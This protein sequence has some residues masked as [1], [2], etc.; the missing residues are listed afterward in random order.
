MEPQLILIN[1]WIHDFAAYDLWSKPLGLLYLAGCLRER[2][3]HI[4]LTDCLDVHHPGMKT[5]PSLSRPVRRAYGT[6]KFRREKIPT[7]EPL[8]HI[9]RSY[10]RYGISRDVFV[11]DL[12]EVRNPAAI[13]VT[14]LMTYWYPGVQE[15]V[16]LAKKIHPAVP[17]ILGGIYARLCREHALRHSGA[18]RVVTLG[19]TEAL[20]GVLSV[21]D[22]L[23]VPAPE[24]HPP[25][26]RPP[27]PAFD[28]LRRIDYICLLTSTGCPYRC[29]YCASPFLT[30]RFQQRDS[31]LVLEEILYWHGRYGVRDFAFYDDAL[32]VDSGNHIGV[33]LGALIK[34]H[35]GLRFHTPNAL[36]VREISREMAGLLFA[37]GFRTIRLGLET[38]DMNRHRDLDGKVSEGEFER[39]VGNLKRAGFT[40]RDIG[41]Y[42]LAGLP[43]QPADSVLETVQFVGA[44]GATPHLAE[45]SP[46]PHTPMWEKALAHS[47]YDLASEPLFHNNTLLPCWDEIQRSRVPDLKKTVREIRRDGS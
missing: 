8:R 40:K 36:H 24:D 32:L 33:V 35:L 20:D 46:I 9:A 42:I 3:F 31:D 12:G 45:Y 29:R 16:D 11:R 4:H 18:D 17:V 23:G 30:P 38:S 47:D 2:G 43:G 34:R 15:A 14:S 41:A 37:S 22:E 39:A 19:G 28:M 6:G 5:D 10:S 7:P 1:P 21:L 13:L 25:P 26:E 27:Y 44:A